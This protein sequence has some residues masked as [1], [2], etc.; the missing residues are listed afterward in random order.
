MC[1]IANKHNNNNNEDVGNITKR[2]QFNTIKNFE[3]VS[4]KTC[5]FKK[6]KL[7]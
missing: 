4:C 5:R 2:N 7:F 1:K 3:N 6:N